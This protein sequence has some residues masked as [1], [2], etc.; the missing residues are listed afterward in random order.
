MT[1]VHAAFLGHKDFDLPLA[2]ADND[3]V[4][5]KDGDH[6][7]RTSEAACAHIEEPIATRALCAML[8]E[9]SGQS[10]SSAAHACRGKACGACERYRAKIPGGR[11]TP[12]LSRAHSHLLSG[13]G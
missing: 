8:I 10:L 1:V 5:P 4:R 2:L 7:A 6:R 13:R 3:G 12:C 9:E 11:R